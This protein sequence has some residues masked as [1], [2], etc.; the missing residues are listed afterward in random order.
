MGSEGD[1]PQDRTSRAALAAFGALF[2]GLALAFV[3]TLGE[4]EPRPHGWAGEGWA[5]D[6]P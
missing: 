5:H 3:Q 1:G 2:A 4:A 6:A